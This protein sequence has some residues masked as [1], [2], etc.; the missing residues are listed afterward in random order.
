M[1]TDF[2]ITG[3]ASL[4]GSGAYAFSPEAYL[5]QVTGGPGAAASAPNSFMKS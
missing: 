2:G 3:S 4:T 5:N 1:A